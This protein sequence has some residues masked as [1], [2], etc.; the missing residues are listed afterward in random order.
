MDGRAEG[1]HPPASSSAEAAC[2]RSRPCTPP[3]GATRIARPARQPP[4]A[5]PHS[6]C[7]PRD[8]PTRRETGMRRGS[9]AVPGR[10]DIARSGCGSRRSSSARRPRVCARSCHA[11]HFRKCNRPDGERDRDPPRPCADTPCSD[12]FQS[13]G[14][15]RWQSGADRPATPRRERFGCGR[16]G[17]RRCRRGIDTSTSCAAEGRIPRRAPNGPTRATR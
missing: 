6:C 8:R 13:A 17:S 16:S 12:L 9:P 1:V 7:R 14:T 15:T 11:R 2:A 5:V 10:F 3:P 4:G